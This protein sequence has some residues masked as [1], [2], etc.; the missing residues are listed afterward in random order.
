MKWTVAG[1]TITAALVLVSAQLAEASSD[2]AD[3]TVP[4]VVSFFVYDIAMSTNSSAQTV[5]VTNIDMEDWLK[6]SLKADAENF[7]P[8]VGGA[9]TWSAGD[10]SWNAAT[11]TGGTGVAG[12]LSSTAY[13]EVAHAG[14]A[15]SSTSTSNLVFTLAAKPTVSRA[16]AH[17]LSVR[18]R[19]E[20]FELD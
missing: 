17:T 20:R 14:E 10:I 18:W 15:P 12:S 1:A 5:T 2:T 11:W 7:T 4:A 16:G 13:N 9:T 8:P 3:V 19:F 6:I